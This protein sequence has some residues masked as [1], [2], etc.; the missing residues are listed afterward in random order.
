MLSANQL[1]DLL[2]LEP[3]P[4]EGGYFR[5]T[6][7]AKDTVPADAL[8]KRY[9][10]SMPIGSCI[11]YLITIDNFSAM[12]RLQTDEIYHFYSGDPVELLLLYPEGSGEIVK[13]GTDFG[14]GM[15]PQFVVSRG[16]WQGSIVQPNGDFGYALIGTTMAPAYDDASFELGNKADLMAQYPE[17]RAEINGRF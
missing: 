7:L 9:G 11:Y 17:F 14:A 12:H 8:P 1:I 5:R 13:L 4:H 10:R 6:Y 3:L 16:A 2:N 15:H